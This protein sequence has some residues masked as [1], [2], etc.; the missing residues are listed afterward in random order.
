LQRRAAVMTPFAKALLPLAV[1]AALLGPS[2]SSL[3]PP[4]MHPGFG[5]ILRSRSLEKF[6]P[7]VLEDSDG[8]HR[9]AD[10]PSTGL[11]SVLRAAAQRVGLKE[12]FAVSLL[13]CKGWPLLVAY[14]EPFAV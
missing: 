9:I 4:T 12:V 3:A 7:K 6:E 11:D 10:L 5:A 8:F 14:M 2:A 1:L 13:F